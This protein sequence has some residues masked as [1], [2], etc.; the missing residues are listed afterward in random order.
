[1]LVLDVGFRPPIRM[2]DLSFG[3]LDDLQLVVAGY[4]TDSQ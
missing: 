1:M 3:G 4:N 2:G